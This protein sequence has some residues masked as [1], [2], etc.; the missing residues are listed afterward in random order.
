MLHHLLTMAILVFATHG[1]SAPIIEKNE[2]VEINWTKLRLGFYGFA[3]PGPLQS[4]EDL[5]LME[6]KAWKDGISYISKKSREIYLSTF[7]E[8]DFTVKQLAE[9]SQD[10]SQG[11]AQ[12]TMSTNT[13]YYPGGGVQVVLESGLTNLFSS[14]GL[15]FAQRES[16]ILGSTHY[17]GIYIK[18]NKRTNPRV[19]Y[20]IISEEGKLLFDY[21][22]IAQESFSKVLSGRWL[23]APQEHE[24]EDL[25]GTQPIVLEASV[26]KDGLFQVMRMDW[27]NA[28]LG[29]KGLLS[30][31]NILFGMP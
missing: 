8:V 15:K 30:S 5:K 25:I 6:K 4:R 20:R 28:L 16:G 17:S 19:F 22:S 12:S 24:I 7:E 18:L 9:Y 1:F 11:I 27:E 23:S 14:R 2:R 29:H 31:G 26:V 13:V 10:V 3:K 21:R